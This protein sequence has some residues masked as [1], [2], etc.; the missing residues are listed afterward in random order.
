MDST[1]EPCYYNNCQKVIHKEC[2]NKFVYN[3]GGNQ[4]LEDPITKQ[5]YFVCSKTC[6]TKVKKSHISQTTQRNWNKD[7]KYG[8]N[9]P[10]TSERILLNWLLA[11]GNYQQYRGKDNNGKTK[12]DFAKQIKILI[13]AAEVRATRTPDTIKA[14]IDHWEKKYYEAH[15][16]VHSETGAGI[17]VRNP[18]G[19][20]GEVKK[21]FLYYYELLPIFGDRAKN[22]PPLTT[23]NMDDQPRARPAAARTN[24]LL[25]SSDD[26]EQDN[27]S[28]V[29]MTDADDGDTK[30]APTTLFAES[31]KKRTKAGP[32]MESAK[33][34]K[35]MT[36]TEQRFDFLIDLVK[37]DREERRKEKEEQRK[38]AAIREVT[39]EA[40][41]LLKLLQLKK[42]MED[43]NLPQSEIIRLAPSLSRFYQTTETHD[44]DGSDSSST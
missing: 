39:D 20:P 22:N 27:T 7:G 21:R 26:E 25:D 31:G 41:Q 13:D 40:E 43:A 2:C 9:D 32:S 1:P 18:A 44:S 28:V 38:R 5:V 36:T 10:N 17:L 4:P 14:K 35:T 11:E 37:Q 12:L 15:M 24:T 42:Q 3:V 29:V 8:V 34:R 33:K 30:P 16:F 23:A 6:Y 19:F